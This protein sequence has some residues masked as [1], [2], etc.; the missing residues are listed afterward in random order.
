VVTPEVAALTGLRTGTPVNVSAVDVLSVNVAW[1]GDLMIMYRSATFVILA[2]NEGTVRSLPS[3]WTV[4]GACAG[5][6][7][8]AAGMSTTGNLTKWFRDTLAGG[9]DDAELFAEAAQV[10][11]RAAGLLVLPYF[12]GG[13]TPICDDRARGVIAGLSPSHP[14]AELFRDVL[15]GV[16]FD[17]RYLLE[18][19]LEQGADVRRV[20][21][22][23]G[24]AQTGTWLQ[25]VSD[26][27][28]TEQQVP[29]VTTGASYGN[30]FLAGLAAGV[31]ER[32]AL[33]AWVQ[34]GD[35]VKP[36]TDHRALYDARYR[37]C[38]ELYTAARD[39][40]HRLAE[41]QATGR[42]TAS[43][44]GRSEDILVFALSVQAV[45]E[46]PASHASV[47]AGGRGGWPRGT[48]HSASLGRA[49]GAGRSGRRPAR[50]PGQSEWTGRSAPHR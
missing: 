8:L 32:E 18:T 34:P 29:A 40:V 16:G 20:V 7:N 19:F 13:R 3:L 45:A 12:S 4:G 42:Q 22:A 31:L 47:S 43:E 26:I 25:I 30:A 24:G 38:L 33:D 27:A 14:R 46:L 48:R 50:F 11:A 21:P 28:G 10:P 9:Q 1:P 41:A 39:V 6:L 23:G 37:D 36:N 44:V 5:Q 49:S 35:T 17:V 2:Q 15:E